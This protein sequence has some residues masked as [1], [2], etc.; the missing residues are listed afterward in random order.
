M[1][2]IAFHYTEKSMFCIADGLI[3]RG[4]SRVIEKDKKIIVINPVY[5]IPVVSLGR[6]SHFTEYK[7]GK[8]CIAYAGNY[9]LISTILKSFTEIVT[10]KLVLKRSNI[11]VPT[12]YR[13]D[14]EGR[15]MR[16]GD[17]WDNNN[18][19]FDFNDLIPITINFLANILEKVCNSACNDFAINAMQE[20]DIELLIFGSEMVGHN[21]TNR[22]Q[23]LFCKAYDEKD[24]VI[25]RNSVLPWSLTCLGDH[26]VIPLLTKSIENNLQYK[27]SLAGLVGG[28]LWSG[29]PNNSSEYIQNRE[30]II[31]NN[32][33]GRIKQNLGTIGG[34]CTIAQSGWTQDIV[35]STIGYS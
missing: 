20:P 6:F 16:G 8:F 25:I 24:S 2:I 4:T 32:V 26:T 22:A 30:D 5:K 9:T 11:G 17:Y 27:I 13:A 18:F 29:E 34:D 3:S 12:V 23:I 31:K 33:L 15:H 1:T 10:Q 7:G 19:D 28:S 14:D 21:S 35:L